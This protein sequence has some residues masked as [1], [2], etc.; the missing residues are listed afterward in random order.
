[1]FSKY[2]EELT[3]TDILPLCSILTDGQLAIAE[4]Y[5]ISLLLDSADNDKAVWDDVDKSVSD[6]AEKLKLTT[7]ISIYT[8]VDRAVFADSDIALTSTALRRQASTGDNWDDNVFNI[9]AWQWV[10]IGGMAAAVT[11]SVIVAIYI[12]K[13]VNT[14]PT[15]RLPPFDMESDYVIDN[16]VHV[17]EQSTMNLSIGIAVGVALIS[18]GVLVG[19]A[20]YNYYHP[21]YLDIPDIMVDA[22]E[23][24]NGSTDYVIY[25]SVKDPDGHSSDTNVWEGKQWNAVY[26]TKDKN[27]GSPILA[28]FIYE[29]GAGR[30]MSTDKENLPMHYFGVSDVAYNTNDHIYGDADPIYVFFKTDP[31][32]LIASA[33]VFT[34]GTLALAIGL[35]ALCGAGIGTFVTF[36]CLKKKMKPR[37]PEQ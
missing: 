5:G 6:S 4:N 14:I 2:A 23:D 3:Y 24:E 27:A 21:T 7:G 12:N 37:V 26:T 25:H 15:Y 22:V 29:V 17:F 11:A 32:A 20:F 1:M 34:G 35:V 10:A 31:N 16:T 8:G 33:S 13:A 18:V 28:S 19:M 9:G 36:M 30:N